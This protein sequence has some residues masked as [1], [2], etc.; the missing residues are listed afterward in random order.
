MRASI[1]RQNLLD[2][3]INVASIRPP[4]RIPQASRSGAASSSNILD[5]VVRIGASPKVRCHRALKIL[6]SAILVRDT[7]DSLLP[8]HDLMHDHFGW[9]VAYSVL[10]EQSFDPSSDSH[11]STAKHLAIPIAE[12]RSAVFSASQDS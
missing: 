5:H 8:E 11:T 3:D 9:P 4:R 6:T 2:T 7:P 1:E 12:S 10:L